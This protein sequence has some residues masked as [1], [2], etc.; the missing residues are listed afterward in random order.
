M[1]EP[2]LSLCTV[3]FNNEDNIEKFIRN[4]EEVLKG[5]FVK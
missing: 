5:V 1:V 2:K 3:T 4:V